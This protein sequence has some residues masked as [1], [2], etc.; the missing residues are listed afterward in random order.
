MIAVNR[1]PRPTNHLY[2]A[3]LAVLREFNLPMFDRD[4]ARRIENEIERIDKDHDGE[5]LAE[6]IA[7]FR[8][9]TAPRGTRLLS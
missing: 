1:E 9:R 6:L 2:I 3:V 5:D 7:G 4:D 8:L